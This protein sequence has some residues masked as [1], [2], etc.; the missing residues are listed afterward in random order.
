MVSDKVRAQMQNMDYLQTVLSMDCLL[1][2]QITLN[3]MEARQHH[4]DSRHCKPL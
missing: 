3:S 4:E 2:T 1:L